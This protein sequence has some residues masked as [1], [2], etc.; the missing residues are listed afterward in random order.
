MVV[1]PVTTRIRGIETEVVLDSKDGMPRQ[2]AI[3]LDNLRTVPK[4]LLTEQITQL[5][6]ERLQEICHALNASVDC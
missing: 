4:A 5:D 6:A 3:S 2:C 1:A